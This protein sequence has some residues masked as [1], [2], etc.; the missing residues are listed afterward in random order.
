M[1]NSNAYFNLRLTCVVELCPT[2]VVPFLVVPC[3]PSL[4]LPRR[5]VGTKGPGGGGHGAS[6]VL[7]EYQINKGGW[8]FFVFCFLYLAG[9][10]LPDSKKGGKS[11]QSSQIN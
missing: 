5:S 2:C 3:K 1:E 4:N 10:K 6:N 11:Q 7:G 9:Y 8:L